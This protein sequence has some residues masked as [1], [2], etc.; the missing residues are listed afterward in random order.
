MYVGEIVYSG[1]I[2]STNFRIK[3]EVIKY[4]NIYIKED[5]QQKRY[6]YN[7]CQKVLELKHRK[8]RCL[9]T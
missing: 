3:L 7:T 2:G 1:R 6:T 4:K 5:F 8:E 9:H